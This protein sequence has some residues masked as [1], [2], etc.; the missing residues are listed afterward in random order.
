MTYSF[1]LYGV[2]DENQKCHSR[3]KEFIVQSEKAYVKGSLYQLNCGL[4]LMSTEGSSL[5]PGHVVSMDFPETY[6]AVLDMLCGYDLSAP[7][8]SFVTRKPVEV[9]GIEA[10]NV[11]AQ[12]YCLNVDKKIAGLVKV[13]EQKVADSFKATEESLIDKLTERQKTYIQKLAQAR[14]REIVP[15]DMA[16]YRELMSLEL[17]VDKGRRLALTRLGS[18][19]S[20]FL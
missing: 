16:L 3:F 15:V 2:Y 18:E 13:E 8:R 5:I 11:Q 17:I 4:A 6:L 9:L 7:K 19:I 12:A 20:L 10:A 14:G 1:F